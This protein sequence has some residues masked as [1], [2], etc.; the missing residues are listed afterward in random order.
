MRR[1]FTGLLI[2]LFIPI[3]L[4]AAVYKWTDK[5]GN[6]VFSDQ[7][8][9]GAEKIK[10]IPEQLYSSPPIMTDKKVTPEDTKI[11][12]NKFAYQALSMITPTDQQT[13]W[14]AHGNVAVKI[15]VIPELQAEDKLV[16]FLEGKAVQ[17]SH[18]STQ[19]VLE[20]INRGTHRLMVEI[21]NKADKKIL[22]TQTVIF[23]MHRPTVKMR[24][25]KSI[26]EITKDKPL[27]EIKKPE[28][29]PFTPTKKN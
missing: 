18:S 3:A 15:K 4:N 22:S 17:E 29:T 9:K 16:L 19:F 12:K 5:E 23:Y 1:I 24:D 14:S 21:Q 13:F 20:N 25:I 7:P 11:T 28:T 8:H 6:P 10:L 2:I 27:E 26:K